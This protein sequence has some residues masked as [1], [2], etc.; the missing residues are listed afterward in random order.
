MFLA[1]RVKSYREQLNKF[2]VTG[3]QDIP[4]HKINRRIAFGIYFV[5]P[6]IDILARIVIHMKIEWIS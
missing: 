3:I 5:F 6:V 2:T 1:E 4:G